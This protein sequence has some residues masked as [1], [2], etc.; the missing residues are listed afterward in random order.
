MLFIKILISM[1]LFLS[2]L[3][4]W[5]E[6]FLW[7]ARFLYVGI[8][9]PLVYQKIWF[10]SFACFREPCN[11]LKNI[12]WSCVFVI[13]SI[14]VADIFLFMKVVADE[15]QGIMPFTVACIMFYVCNKAL[16]FFAIMYLWNCKYFT[17]KKNKFWDITF[18]FSQA[19]YTILA[20]PAVAWLIFIAVAFITKMWLK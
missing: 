11:R 16:Y 4:Y 17:D 19:V 10:K 14:F 1:I 9:L 18:K 12:L 7:T 6:N 13:S 5:P 15:T 20:V 2:A 8:I 3:V